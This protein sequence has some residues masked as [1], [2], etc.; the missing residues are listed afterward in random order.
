M[1]DDLCCWSSE[2]FHRGSLMSTY[3]ERILSSLGSIRPID[4]ISDLSH[5]LT[6]I[7]YI[8]SRI[9][10]DLFEYA[11]PRAHYF[12]EVDCSTGSGFFGFLFSATFW[13]MSYLPYYFIVSHSRRSADQT[14]IRRDKG[15]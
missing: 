1:L 9:S 2:A 12:L 7:F 4:T 10:I 6:V 3:C 8:P 11:L 13:L 5:L 14:S 15:Y